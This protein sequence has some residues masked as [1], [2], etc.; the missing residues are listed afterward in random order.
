M[1]RLFERGALDVWFTPIQMKKNRPA[2]MLSVLAPHELEGEIVETMLRETSTLGVRVQRVARHESQREII[3]FESSLG[4]V[5]VK[6]KRLQGRRV[7]LSPEFEDCRR[8]AQE[9]GLPLQEV[10][11]IV[12]AEASAQFLEE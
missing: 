3:R 1:E 7:G 5:M 8:L 2:V 10:Y 4:E 12:I 11:R 6:V 9:H